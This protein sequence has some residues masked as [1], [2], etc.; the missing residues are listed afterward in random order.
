VPEG[1]RATFLNTAVEAQKDFGRVTLGV[2]AGY[3][4]T[5]SPSGKANA[6]LTD[7]DGWY[8][9]GVARWFPSDNLMV[10]GDFGYAWYT[11]AFN[12]TANVARWGARL[13]Y[14]MPSAAMAAFVAY[15]GYR[16]E[17]GGGI[18][19]G[20]ADIHAVTVGLTF[21]GNGETLAARYRGPAG[22]DDRNPTYGVNY[23][24]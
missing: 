20:A 21:I 11:A 23:V 8:V 12:Q 24:E 13:E 16:W 19:D 17:Q 3:V 9:H 1:Y 18:S 7:P 4:Q 10:A 14:K 5:I 2:Q 15:H 22:L 6:S